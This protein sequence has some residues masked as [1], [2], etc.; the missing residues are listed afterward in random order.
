[1]TSFDS[2]VSL[3]CYLSVGCGIAGD[4]ARQGW[5]GERRKVFRTSHFTG[6]V[7]A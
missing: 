2:V 4:K 6:A 5:S 1:M 7:Q 3:F